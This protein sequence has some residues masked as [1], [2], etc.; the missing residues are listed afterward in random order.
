[1]VEESQTVQRTFLMVPRMPDTVRTVA[2]SNLAASSWLLNMPPTKAW[3]RAILKGVP[4]SF[5][6]LTTLGAAS[7]PSTTPVALIRH[8]CNQYS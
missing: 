7:R 2:P 8:P 6:F 1:M 3:W 4:T 5:S